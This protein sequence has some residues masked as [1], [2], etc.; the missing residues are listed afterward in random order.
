MPVHIALLRAVNV[1]GLGLAMAD[2][3]AMLGVL[4]FAQ[5]RTVLQSGNVVFEAGRRTGAALESFLEAETASRLGV[6]CDYLVRA[7]GQ[8]SEIVAGNPFPEQARRDPGRLV[9]MPLKAVPGKREV[10]ALQAAI[11]GP[12]TVRAGGRVLYIVYPDGM[13]RSRLTLSSIEK[14]LST[15]GTARNWNTTL[16]LQTLVEGSA[17][18]GRR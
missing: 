17:P 11:Q 16:K 9:V 4:G 3:K 18:A 15:R 10:E 8:W 6:H 1:G 13:G 5:V 7:P 2:L 12:E 14:K